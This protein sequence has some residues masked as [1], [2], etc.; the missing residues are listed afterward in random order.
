MSDYINAVDKIF[1]NEDIMM[2]KYLLN[3]TFSLNN[4][5]I[6][7]HMVKGCHED[8]LSTGLPILINTQKH[9]EIVLL[10]SYTHDVELQGPLKK[11]WAQYIF[12]KGMS[13][14]KN[15]VSTR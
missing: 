2:E 11:A 13:Y 9:T 14:L 7:E 3:L 4:S 6:Y 10:Y 8:L 1:V 5:C 12:D 15:L